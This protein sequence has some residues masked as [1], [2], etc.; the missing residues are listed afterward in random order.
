MAEMFPHRRE[1]PS[2]PAADVHHAAQSKTYLRCPFSQKDEA[3][4]LGAWWDMAARKWYVPAGKPL[5]SFAR[6]LPS[7]AL[8]AA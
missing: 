5:Q 6:W 3:K 2:P 7:S 4:A 1:P 8:K